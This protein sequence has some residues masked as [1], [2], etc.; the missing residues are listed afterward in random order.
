MQIF[1]NKC[2]ISELTTGK[3][4]IVNENIDFLKYLIL[5]KNETVKT[6]ETVKRVITSSNL[7]RRKMLKLHLNTHTHTHS[8]TYSLAQSLT[9]VLTRSLCIRAYQDTYSH[10]HKNV[11]YTVP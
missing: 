1:S 11:N 4:L 7:S 6:V 3:E 9:Q 10:L 2:S 8:H 5:Q